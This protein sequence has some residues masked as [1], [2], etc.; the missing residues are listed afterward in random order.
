MAQNKN[1]YTLW[2]FHWLCYTNQLF[3]SIEINF[4]VAGHTKF[5]PDRHFGYAKKKLNSSDNVETFS[6]VLKII[7]ESSAQQKIIS[8]SNWLIGTPDV[9]VFDWKTFLSKRYRKAPLD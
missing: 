8:V 4:L 2:F 7:Q 9:H 6:D 1:H 3:E 5:S